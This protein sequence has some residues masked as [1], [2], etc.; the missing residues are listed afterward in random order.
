MLKISLDEGYVFDMLSISQVKIIKAPKE[1]KQK[2]VYNY[3]QLSKEI[4]K[5]IG[6]DLYADIIE[7]KEYQELRNA[8]EKTFDLVDQVKKDN[9]L[10]KLVDDSNYNRYQ[11][12]TA[13]QNKFFN[14]EV[15][16]VK[17]GYRHE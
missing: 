15:K 3:Q 8:N 9:G 11:K 4:I 1:N 14:N 12:K 5:Q 17:I 7:S 13:L 6:F 2:L 16:E 10:A